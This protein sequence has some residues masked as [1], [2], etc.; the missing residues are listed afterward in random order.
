L[1]KNI[2]YILGT[3]GKSAKIRA[4]LIAVASFRWWAA[5]VPLLALLKI[6]PRSVV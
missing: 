4:L 3:K 1:P 2:G 6:L 5:H